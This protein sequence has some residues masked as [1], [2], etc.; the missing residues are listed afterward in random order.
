MAK[1]SENT[2]KNAAKYWRSYIIE[3]K[4]EVLEKVLGTFRHKSRKLKV[5]NATIRR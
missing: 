4:E 3:N 2:K 5:F 1:D